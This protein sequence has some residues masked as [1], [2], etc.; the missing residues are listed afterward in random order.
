MLERG[1]GG[2][3][4]DPIFQPRGFRKTFGELPPSLKK[5]ISHRALAARA[6]GSLLSREIKAPRSKKQV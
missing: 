1:S 6:I 5:R 4:Y 2:F 3:G